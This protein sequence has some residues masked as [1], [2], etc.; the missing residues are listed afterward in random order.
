MTLSGLV[1]PLLAIP[2]AVAGFGLIA[3]LGRAPRV[4][5]PAAQP[6]ATG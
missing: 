2:V 5:I 1:P 6:S 4:P 3:A